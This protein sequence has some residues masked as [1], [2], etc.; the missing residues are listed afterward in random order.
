MSYNNEAKCACA[1]EPIHPPVPLTELMKETNEVGLAILAMAE[2]IEGNLF[3]EGNSREGVNPSPTCFRHALDNHRS[4]LIL[5]ADAL[6]R[7][8]NQLGV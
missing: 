7:I 1:P 8:C 6:S 4:T 3:G 2:K 5:A